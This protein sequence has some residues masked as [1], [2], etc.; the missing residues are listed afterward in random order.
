M[1]ILGL[2]ILINIGNKGRMVLWHEQQGN[3][4]EGEME[5]EKLSI[6]AKKS[7][8]LSRLIFL[9]ALACTLVSARQFAMKLAGYH[10]WVDVVMGA[11]LV[12]QLLN[13]FLYPQ[14]EYRQWKYAVDEEKL[15]FSEGI[16]FIEH[17]IVP[18]ERIQHIKIEQG[19]IN[20]KLGLASIEIHT[21]GGSFSIPNLEKDKAEQIGQFL[22]SSVSDKLKQEGNDNG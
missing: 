20:R 16:Y 15:E 3:L 2:C 4:L 13:T 7:W 21:A 11:V 5:F 14:I 9:I 19:P 8:F 10:L 17:T 6:K 12:L 18:I 1:L 22:R